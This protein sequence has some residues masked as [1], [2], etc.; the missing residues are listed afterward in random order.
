MSGHRPAAPAAA[1]S[2]GPAGLQRVAGGAPRPLASGWSPA[3]I[4]V[5][6]AATRTTATATAWRPPPAP[7]RSSSSPTAAG[8]IVQRVASPPQHPAGRDG[9]P[10]RQRWLGPAVGATRGRGAVGAGEW[11]SSRTRSWSTVGARRCAWQ[12]WTRRYDPALAGSRDRLRTYVGGCGGWWGRR[13]AATSAHDSVRS[14]LAHVGRP[15]GA[16][17]YR[18]GATAWR[19]TATGVE[20]DPPSSRSSPSGP[21]AVPAAPKG[22][23]RA[24]SRPPATCW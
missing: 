9:V 7:A 18:D 12:S 13:V 24:L 14:R 23:G 10:G 2:P 20:Q 3:L 21:P 15:L 8:P 5:V 22:G 16:N 1:A 6:P 19:G 4:V 11:C 17:L